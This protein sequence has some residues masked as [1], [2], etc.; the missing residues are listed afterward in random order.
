M[1]RKTFPPQYAGLIEEVLR[2]YP[3]L[4]YTSIE[5]RLR[6][7]HP[8]PYGTTPDLLSVV[9]K[10]SNRHYCIS[11]LEQADPPV[12]AV[13]FKHLTPDMQ[14]GVIAHE[15]FHVV[16]FQSCSRLQLLRTI[17]SYPSKKFL[18]SFEREADKGAIDHGYGRELYTHAVYIRSIPEYVAER[19]SLDTNY[20]LPD[21]I[22]EYMKVNGYGNQSRQ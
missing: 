22:L 1:H 21:E 15:L 2:S 13:L 16:Q 7:K 5:V 18:R 9:K 10:P 11:I 6:K 8:V 14:K 20:L 19:P 4:A 12:E 3:E 17:V